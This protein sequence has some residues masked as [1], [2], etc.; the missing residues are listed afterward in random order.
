MT[1]PTQRSLKL[2]RDSGWTAQIVEKYNSY[3]KKRIDL[4]D[5]IDIVILTG[6]S[7]LGVQTTSSSN[8][9]ARST[10]ALESP[11][12]KLWLKSGG[13]FEIWGW[14]K[15]GP[16]GK[17]KLW[18]LISQAF[19]LIGDDIVITSTSPKLATSYEAID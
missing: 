10:K 11:K 14:G 8:V 13:R 3:A 4:F 16:R 1:S 19:E 12:L 2:A 5:C 7:I 6:F 17:R 9:P 15:S 18:T